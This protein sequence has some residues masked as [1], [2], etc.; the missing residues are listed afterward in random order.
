MR[1]QRDGDIGDDVWDC[2]PQDLAIDLTAQLR[3]LY[4]SVH[5]SL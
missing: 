4:L 1:E 2:E 3:I 5:L